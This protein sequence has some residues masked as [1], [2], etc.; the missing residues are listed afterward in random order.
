MAPV[1]WAALVLVLSGLFAVE[2]RAELPRI[3]VLKVRAE[4]GIPQGTA[5]LLGEI[6]IQDVHKSGKYEALGM[7]DVGAVLDVEQQKQVVGCEDESCL[8]EIGS[9]LGVDLILDSSVGTVGVTRVLALKLIDVRKVVV[10]ARETETVSEDQALIGAMHRLV[11]RLLGIS[12]RSEPRADRGTSPA[13]F[14]LG[15]GAVL[16]G[17]GA[18]F[19][20]LALGDYHDFEARPFDDPLGDSAKTKALVADGLYAAAGVAIVAGVI[21]LVTASSEGE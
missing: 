9:A 4:Q 20:V 8:A 13:W 18:L 2:A 1:Q 21:W 16:A 3:L 6:L 15:G 17:A 11:A 19:G 10:K 12:E 5:N 7:S 14:V